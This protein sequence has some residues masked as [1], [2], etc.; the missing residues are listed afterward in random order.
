MNNENSFDY[1]EETPEP[2]IS[3]TDELPQNKSEAYGPSKIEKGLSDFRIY[4]VASDNNLLNLVSRSDFGDGPVADA[5]QRGLFF[6]TQKNM[7]LEYRY[8]D[9]PILLE[10]NGADFLESLLTLEDQGI[11]IV[12]FNHDEVRTYQ[13]ILAN[14][15]KNPTEIKNFLDSHTYSPE[16]ISLRGL[17]KAAEIVVLL[18]EGLDYLP[19]SKYKKTGIKSQS[20]NPSF[21]KHERLLSATGSFHGSTL[22]SEKTKDSHLRTLHKHAKKLEDERGLLLLDY[23]NETRSNRPDRDERATLIKIKIMDKEKEIA[24]LKNQ[25]KEYRAGQGYPDQMQ[26]YTWTQNAKDVAALKKLEEHT[27]KKR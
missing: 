11:R 7:A 22:S 4:R 20:E 24:L 17:R 8:H 3:D 19:L 6:S 2:E 16:Q 26:E 5:F 9:K 12:L 1:Q 10:S 23:A 15:I 27:K 25:I 18:P 21:G 13:K 14:K